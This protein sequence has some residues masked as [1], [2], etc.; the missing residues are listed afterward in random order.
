MMQSRP[1]TF[2]AFRKFHCGDEMP[3]TGAFWICWRTNTGSWWDWGEKSVSKEKNLLVRCL[4]SKNEG[5]NWI[6]NKHKKKKKRKEKKRKEKD[7]RPD[8]EASIC[9]PL[10]SLFWDGRNRSI[11]EA[12]RPAGLAKFAY[13]GISKRLLSQKKRWMLLRG[14]KKKPK[15]L[16]YGL[17]SYLQL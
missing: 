16:T 17:H 9:N 10:Q 6:P 5:L 8:I 1:F 12:Q 11:A 4:P 13:P 7:Q 14:K 2:F 3:V 15:S